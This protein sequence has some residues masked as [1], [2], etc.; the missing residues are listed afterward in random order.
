MGKYHLLNAE[1]TGLD[2]EGVVGATCGDLNK[3]GNRD[4]LVFTGKEVRL[5]LNRGNFRF[6]LDKEFAARFGQ[7]GG[8]SGQFA[9]IDND[10][11][12]DI[13][14][15]DAHRPDGTRGPVV[16]INDWPRGGFHN[17]AEVDPGNLLNAIQVPGDAC[18]VVADFTGDGKLDILLAAMS[19]QPMLIE[20]I[21][22]GGHYLAMDLQGSRRKDQSESRCSNSAIGARV[23]VKSGMV[24]QEYV[25]GAPSG[26]T[27]MPP[28]R[29]HAGLGPNTEVQWL[30]VRWPDSVLQAEL[31][32]AADRVLKISR[33]QSQA[34]LVPAPVCLGRLAV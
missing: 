11:D 28:L 19:E 10:G 33:D 14:I 24:F 26:A 9:D 31:E 34:F 22:P 29:I 25:V 21:T 1:A 17:A 20:N 16:L 27:A 5:Y 23:E 8:T 13:V 32:L 12:L 7:L 4:L 6:E 3:D 15:A 2:V 30:R 18:C